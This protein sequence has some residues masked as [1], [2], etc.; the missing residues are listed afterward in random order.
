MRAPRHAQIDGL[1]KCTVGMP[2]RRRAHSR[3][4]LKSGA[5]TPTKTEGGAAR[6]V[7]LKGGAGQRV[8]RQGARAFDKPAHGHFL[9]GKTGL[10]PRPP[11]L[12]PPN[13]KVAAV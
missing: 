3:P 7:R 6:K 10:K 11:H 1:M 8:F 4:R 12:R 2:A 5:S 9:V 13:P